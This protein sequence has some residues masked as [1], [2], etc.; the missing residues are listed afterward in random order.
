MHNYIRKIMLSDLLFGVVFAKL[1]GF[2]VM[3]FCNHGGPFGLK[4]GALQ[5]ITSNGRDHGPTFETR[6]GYKGS[7]LREVVTM[8]AATRLAHQEDRSTVLAPSL[9]GRFF[10]DLC[11]RV[12][13]EK[14]TLKEWSEEIKL[15]FEHINIKLPNL[16]E[17][18]EYKNPNANAV[19]EILRSMSACKS[20]FGIDLMADVNMDDPCFYSTFD[21][22]KFDRFR[23][24][25]GSFYKEEDKMT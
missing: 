21:W 11:K 23:L 1:T 22:E 19:N 15:I 16:R 3:T 9:K 6:V 5:V 4:F 2:D 10:L 18:V 8:L 24:M 25:G 17:E 12:M 14:T 13:F 7:P 20:Q